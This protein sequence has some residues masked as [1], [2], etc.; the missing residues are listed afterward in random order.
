MGKIFHKACEKYILQF[1]IY[2]LD[3]KRNNNIRMKP[4]IKTIKFLAAL[5]VVLLVVTYCI[6]LNDE[7][8]WIVLNTPWMSNNFAFAITVGS[9]ASLLIVLACELQQY[10]YIKCQTE[11]YIF[12]QLFSLYAQVTVIHYNVKRQLN[13]ISSP[14]PSNLIGEIANRGKMFL[15][16]L[17]SIEILLTK[18]VKSAIIGVTS[19]EM[20]FLEK[21]LLSL[22]I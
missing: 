10:Q 21:K 2:C 14:V 17:T 15:T 13:N 4:S 16:S 8:R 5:S 11:D 7:N 20:L 9:L 12:G 22:L 18:N 19:K 1:S 3:N 6:S